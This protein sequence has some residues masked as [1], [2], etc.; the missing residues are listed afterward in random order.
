MT[1]IFNSPNFEIPVDARDLLNKLVELD[2]GKWERIANN[3][4]LFW[5]RKECHEY[6]VELMKNDRDNSLRAGFPWAVSDLIL[7]LSNLHTLSYKPPPTQM[8][9]WNIW[10]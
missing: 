4:E 1:S 3:I 7:R 6:F 9:M 10:D 2:A 8:T 5:G